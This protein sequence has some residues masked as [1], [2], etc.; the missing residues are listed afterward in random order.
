MTVLSV[1]APEPALLL[2]GVN[3]G[4]LNLGTLCQAEIVLGTQVDA[5]VGQ[6]AGFCGRSVWREGMI[7]TPTIWMAKHHTG[8]VSS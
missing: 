1:S 2:N 8:Y 6:T 5:V 4:L 3:G 7:D